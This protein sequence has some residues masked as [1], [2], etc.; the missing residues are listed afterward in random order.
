MVYEIGRNPY[1]ATSQR[2][3]RKAGAFSLAGEPLQWRPTRPPPGR[4]RSHEARSFCAR[5]GPGFS[6]A[7]L[8]DR[9]FDNL[10]AS[11]SRL[12]PF[13]NTAAVDAEVFVRGSVRGLDTYGTVARSQATFRLPAIDLV[14]HAHFGGAIFST[15]RPET[16]AKAPILS[17][18]S[19]ASAW[20]KVST[21][22][23]SPPCGVATTGAIALR[24]AS[25]SLGRKSLRS[26]AEV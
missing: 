20:W 4:V 16:P 23:R 10:R 15:L 5:S 26:D 18:V 14:C 11:V 24:I 7:A 19:P 13:R 12:T 17:R 2:P 21:L 9:A 3:G 25:I 22:L 8:A 6:V 1:R